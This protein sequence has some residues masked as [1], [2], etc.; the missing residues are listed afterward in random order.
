MT[1]CLGIKTKYGLVGLSDTRITSGNETTTSKKVYT[2]NREKHSF[3]IMTSGLR[4]VRDKAIT[5]FTEVIEDQDESFNKLYKAVNEFGDQIKRVAKE[6]GEQ[7]EKSGLSFNLYSII[8]GQLENDKEPKLY[9]LYPQG[10]WIEI[11]KGTPFV[12]IGNTGAGNPVLRR[13]LSYDDSLDYALKCAFLSFDA[14]RISAND[15]DFPIDTVVLEND[16]YKIKEQR[17]ERS[18]MEHISAFWNNRIKEAIRELPTEVMKKA[19][20]DEVAPMVPITAS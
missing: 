2:V 7:L 10:N 14:T 11:R 20:L 15:V 12:I 18:E 19:F 1:F 8:G 16:R 5:Y 9:L 13:S 17:F 4:S 6:D 3:F